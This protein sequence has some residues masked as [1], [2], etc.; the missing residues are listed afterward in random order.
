MTEDDITRLE[1]YEIL[2]PASDELLQMAA[3]GQV[4]LNALARMEFHARHPEAAQH[5]FRMVARTP[6]H[7]VTIRD[8]TECGTTAMDQELRGNRCL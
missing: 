8:W 4:D 2:R 3:E 1:A 6:V 5:S 7:A